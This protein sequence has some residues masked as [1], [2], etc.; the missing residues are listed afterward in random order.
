VARRLRSIAGPIVLAATLVLLAPAVGA[1]H[2]ASAQS[3]D[4]LQPASR[5]LTD[6]VVLRSAHAVAGTPM[7]GTLVVVNHGAK[8][9]EVTSGCGPGFYVTLV[10]PHGT[11]FSAYVQECSPRPFLTLSPGTNR[12]PVTVS[13]D[14]C[15]AGGDSS[16]PTCPP[17]P[18]GRYETK[19]YGF[20]IALPQPRPVFVRLVA[21][22]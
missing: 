19:L 20:G 1:A 6:R 10:R 5:L 7:I 4:G 14:D 2:A 22:A 8:R 21:G 13:T 3:K 17:L 15:P 12:F 18:P 9:M 11:T 16:A